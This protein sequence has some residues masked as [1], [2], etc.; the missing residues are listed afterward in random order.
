MVKVG[1]YRRFRYR[2]ELPNLTKAQAMQTW[3][4]AAFPAARLPLQASIRVV[5]DGSVP[6]MRNW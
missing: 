3:I 1:F 6:S 4:P 2:E 5:P